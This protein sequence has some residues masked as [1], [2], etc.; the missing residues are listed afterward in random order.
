MPLRG[1][2][3]SQRF[4]REL[5]LP[6]LSPFDDSQGAESLALPSVGVGF[7]KRA[8]GGGRKLL[9]Y[10]CLNALTLT[11]KVLWKLWK[12]TVR[13]FHILVLTVG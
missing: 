7:I 2:S 4:S 6:P 1:E 9:K 13:V 3:G 8:L 10:S 11:N 12:L 5:S